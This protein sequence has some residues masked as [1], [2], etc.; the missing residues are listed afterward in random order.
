MFPLSPFSTGRTHIE[1]AAGIDGSAALAAAADNKSPAVAVE[2]VHNSILLVV[3]VVRNTPVG[4]ATGSTRHNN[5]VESTRR[6]QPYRQLHQ[7]QHL[8][9]FHR[10]HSPKPCRTLPVPDYSDRV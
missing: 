8:W 6:L 5:R 1:P 10:L 4:P 3:E 2:A 9:H 7:W